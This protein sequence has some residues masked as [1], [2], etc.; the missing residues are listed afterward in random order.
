[1]QALLKLSRAIDA[2]NLKL[3]KWVAW[4]I[5]VAV[6]VATVNAIIRKVFSTSSNSWL[7]L[8]WYLF[9]AVFLICA[10]WTL[11]ANEHIRIDIVNNMFPKRVRDWIDLLGHAFFLLPFTIVVII[12]GWPF[13]TAS[14]AVNEQSTNAGGLPVWPVKFLV[15]LAFALL[16]LQGI[17]ELIKR[18]AVMRGVIPDPH[19]THQHPLE[20]EVEHII[21]AIE[22]KP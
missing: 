2:V 3:G 8:Q 12:T 11:L 14:L 15:P 7:E 19:A 17:S 1:M 9:S 21:E 16:F 20:A 13:F 10:S 18:F 4:L 6:L 5:L 22:K